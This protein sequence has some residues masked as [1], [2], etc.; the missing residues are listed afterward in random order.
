[1][2]PLVVPAGVNV[3]VT[4]GSTLHAATTADTSFALLFLLRSPQKSIAQRSRDFGDGILVGGRGLPKVT[5][6]AKVRDGAVVAKPLLGPAEQL[7][8]VLENSDG[9]QEIPDYDQAI[10][11]LSELPPQEAAEL[12]E[13]HAEQLRQLV[14]D[15]SVEARLAAVSALAKTRNLDNVPTLIYALTDPNLEVV[16]GAR[17]ALRRISR[18]PSGFALPDES[19]QGER[20]AAI[21]KW[22]AWYLAVRPDARFRPTEFEEQPDDS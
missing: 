5:D 14:D 12:V 7:L 17:D 18:R 15:W 10:D 13:Q 16:R 4:A 21:E 19:T 3:T 11:L 20:L 1:M 6:G 2:P 9:S 22:K 8:A